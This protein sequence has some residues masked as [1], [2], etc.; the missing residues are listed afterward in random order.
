MQCNLQHLS[1]ISTIGNIM[2]W[3]I[4]GPREREREYGRS[5]TLKVPSLDWYFT[6]T[7]LILI[8]MDHTGTLGL[9]NIQ[10]EKSR[11]WKVTVVRTTTWKSANIPLWFLLF[12]CLL[13]W[14]YRQIYSRNIQSL[15]KIVK[16]P[17]YQLLLL[18]AFPYNF[19]SQFHKSPQYYLVAD[20]PEINWNMLLKVLPTIC[21]TSKPVWGKS[22][23]CFSTTKSF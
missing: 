5:T 2:E 13:T 21:G 17:R 1:W 12:I 10:S 20:I 4:I 7:Q 8:D 9:S 18:N 15:Y 3:M 16:I 22:N 11:L 19:A 6:T 14:R 23:G